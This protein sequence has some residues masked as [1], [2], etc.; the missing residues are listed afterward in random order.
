MRLLSFLRTRRIDPAAKQALENYLQAELEIAAIQG[1]AADDYNSAVAAFLA[2]TGRSHSATEEEMIIQR[3][4]EAT[5]GYLESLRAA[6]QRHSALEPP[7]DAVENF[8]AHEV[9]YR[10]YVHWCERRLYVYSNAGYL[11]N[12]QL[13]E[14]DRADQGFTQDKKAADRAKAKLLRKMG[15]TPQQ[16]TAMMR[17]A[18]PLQ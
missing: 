14:V 11:S 8:L 1:K 4:V 16:L 12:I 18:G 9:L 6:A 17:R 7:A 10:S 2:E 13:A 3:V 5:S 15:I